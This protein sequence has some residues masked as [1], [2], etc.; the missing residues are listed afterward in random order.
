MLLAES[1]IC[2][3][4]SKFDFSKK[5]TKNKKKQKMLYEELKFKKD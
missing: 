3:G 2:Q 4:E 5:Q 1:I